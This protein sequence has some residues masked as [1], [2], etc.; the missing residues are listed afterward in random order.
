M[1]PVRHQR[2]VEDCDVGRD[3]SMQL[4]PE[5]PESAGVGSPSESSVMFKTLRVYVS[6]IIYEKSNGEQCMEVT[7]TDKPAV[8]EKKEK[9]AKAKGSRPAKA[10]SSRKGG[11]F[12]D[13]ADEM[14]EEADDDPNA[15]NIEDSD[16]SGEDEDGREGKKGGTKRSKDQYEDDGFVIPDEDGEKSEGDSSSGDG[17]W[18]APSKEKT[19]KT[20]SGHGSEEDEESGE[21]DDKKKKKKKKHDKKK[22]HREVES[23]D[24]KGSGSE[25]E[26]KKKKKHH[27]HHK[28]EKKE[29]EEDQGQEEKKET[30]DEGRGEEEEEQ[31]EEGK[32]T[33]EAPTVSTV[34][35]NVESCAASPAP[36]ASPPPP[37]SPATVAI[38]VDGVTAPSSSLPAPVTTSPAGELAAVLSSPPTV[39]PPPSATPDSKAATEDLEDI[40]ESFDIGGEDL[41]RKR[42]KETAKEAEKKEEEGEEENQEQEEEEEKKEETRS[43]SSTAKKKG[44]SAEPGEP[45]EV[46]GEL[47][48]EIRAGETHRVEGRWPLNS[49]LWQLVIRVSFLPGRDVK[50]LEDVLL[51]ERTW[52]PP[53]T[54]KKILTSLNVLGLADPAG[55]IKTALACLTG[56]PTEP[57]KV[58]NL[59]RVS[60]RRFAWMVSSAILTD[61]EL[62]ISAA[63]G[64]PTF[65]SL[66][67]SNTVRAEIQKYLDTCPETLLFAD[68]LI[69]PVYVKGGLGELEFSDYVKL[70]DI[71]KSSSDLTLL[72][73][74]WRAYKALRTSVTV[75]GD[76]MTERW[77]LVKNLLPNG[78]EEGAGGSSTVVATAAARSETAKKFCDGAIIHL[79]QRKCVIEMSEEDPRK[80]DAVLEYVALTSVY[81]KEADLAQAILQKSKEK[82]ASGGIP[83]TACGTEYD[84]IMSGVRADLREAVE[85]VEKM[86]LCVI[87]GPEEIPVCL[88]SVLSKL[89]PAADVCVLTFNP[90]TAWTPVKALNYYKDAQYF[91]N[92]VKEAIPPLVMIIEAHRASTEALH[93][94]LC[95]VQSRSKVVI[96]GDSYASA[97]LPKKGEIGRPFLAICQ[98]PKDKVPRITVGS[99]TD[100][101]GPEAVGELLLSDEHTPEEAIAAARAA[102]GDNFALVTSESELTLKSADVYLTTS[103]AEMNKL[104]AS[105]E[106]CKALVPREKNVFHRDDLVCVKS[107]GRRVAAGRVTSVKD[108]FDNLLASSE[109]L[110]LP[111]SRSNQPSSGLAAASSAF[112]GTDVTVQCED[113][114]SVGA[115]DAVTSSDRYFLEHLDVANIRTLPPF[116]ADKV[117]L[118]VSLNTTARD[119]Y[120]AAKIARRRLLLFAGGVGAVGA[121]LRKTQ[122][123][124]S[125]L[126]FALRH[127]Q[128]K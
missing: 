71:K 56:K 65:E 17:E 58:E 109:S 126:T 68:E 22:K 33:E 9:K 55:P 35:E 32:V 119:I 69:P 102:M 31:E 91:E 14:D 77:R 16:E 44:A 86:P 20:K 78:E 60:D 7:E 4:L 12:S 117:C 79:Y 87:D 81:F 5:E 15:V 62:K 108:G 19:K 38:A 40:V 45:A 53:L 128:V 99:Q 39:L 113:S 54:R 49:P 93:R 6:K 92:H 125:V 127:G 2:S 73:A 8:P 30:K 124:L 13:E 36:I 1:R 37:S 118:C 90:L 28:E 3:F 11:L 42:R 84:R 95:A 29:E 41:S 27:H 76:T 63:L 67:R 96:M 94:V 115:T 74:A 122:G 48:I 80:R 120:A 88:L 110:R 57:V 23:E 107:N 21:E 72:R 10:K 97:P 52:E 75:F 116:R 26:S 66:W 59:R 83:G 103:V 43:S 24:D 123:P 51:T 121:A 100:K 25:K 85:L 89:N 98:C 50:K 105:L 64:W 106:K 101:A 114:G 34:D 70:P 18:R 104:K 111:L 82:R 61:H 47:H 112:A 46:T